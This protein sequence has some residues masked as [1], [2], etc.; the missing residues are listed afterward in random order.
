MWYYI[1]KNDY[2][3]YMTNEINDANMFLLRNNYSVKNI[4][5]E[6]GVYI[7]EVF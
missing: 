5:E 7:V 1:V 4:R 2:I 3:E 6:R